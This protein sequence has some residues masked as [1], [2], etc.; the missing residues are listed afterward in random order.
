MSDRLLATDNGTQSVKVLAFDPDGAVVGREQT[1]FTPY[2]SPHPGWA[3]QDPDVWWEALCRSCRRLFS[4]NPDL[5]DRLSGVG[6]T[7]QRGTV[8][9]LDQNARV[10][11]PAILWLDQRKTHGL[12]PMDGPWG[13]LFKLL[14]LSGTIA[15]IR[16]EAEANWIKTFEP[17]VW[18]QTKSYLLLSGWLTLKLTGERTD[19]TGCQVGYIPLHYKRLRWPKDRD[20]RWKMAP[21]RRDMFPRLIPPGQV[22]GRITKAASVET[23][24]PEGLPLIAAGAD[25]ACEVIGSG[26]LDPDAA[27]ISYSTTATVN[28]THSRYVEPIP[29]LPAYPAAMPGFYSMEVQVYRGYWMVSW[30]KEEFGH[31]EQADALKNGMA[32]EDLFDRMLE[33]VP[34]GSMGLV[35]QPYWSPGLRHPGPDAKGAVVGFGD[36]HTRAH[37]YRSILEGIAFGL[38]EGLERIEKRAG[39]NITS[40]NVSGGG[41]KSD[42]ALQL[43]ADAFGLP[44]ARPKV[45]E[46]S[47]LGAAIC[48]AVGTGI[49]PDF[50]SAVSAMTHTGRVFE[51]DPAAHDVYEAL[52]R[53]VYK[54]LYKRLSPLYS[55]IRDITGYPR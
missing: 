30:F 40:L 38:M 19:S 20:W 51:P 54:R 3:E 43:T 31:P 55:E 25:K 50:P 17:E 1:P 48:A 12:P 21:V 11:R 24:I 4:R 27:C 47:G 42:N 41:S 45:R 9:C 29:L 52:Y 2:V 7:T 16:Q 33:T 6:L 36:V 13:L 37:L 14:R 10:L 46:T 39:I 32:A 35:L 18:K 15:Y 22:L 49:F 44:A 8:L 23:G 34:P 26:S 28:V 53:R 5:K